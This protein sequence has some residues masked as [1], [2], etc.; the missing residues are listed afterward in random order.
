MPVGAETH[1][2][3]SPMITVGKT[4]STLRSGASRGW[5]ASSGEGEIEPPCPGVPAVVEVLSP[6]SAPFLGASGFDSTRFGAHP[7]GL[8]LAACR[9]FR[10]KE[11]LN[12]VITRSQDFR[13]SCPRRQAP[14]DEPIPREMTR[15]A[16]ETCL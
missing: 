6:P 15:G 8:W 11:C 12:L 5:V 7:N 10:F 2:R 16:R 13:P 1:E 3:R 4:R 9:D 14:L